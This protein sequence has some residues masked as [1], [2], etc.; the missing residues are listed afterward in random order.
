MI[1]ATPPLSDADGTKNMTHEIENMFNRIFN[2]NGTA[3]QF[4]EI[5][6]RIDKQNLNIK[7]DIELYHVMQ[8]LGMVTFRCVIN[9]LAKNI[10]LEQ[11]LESYHLEMQLLKQGLYK[12]TK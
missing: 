9:K 7:S 6:C 1:A 12:E 2:G 10:P 5:S 11:A 4:K 8:L 3:E